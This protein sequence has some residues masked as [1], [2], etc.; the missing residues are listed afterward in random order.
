[1]DQCSIS[2]TDNGILYKKNTQADI[3]GI[4]REID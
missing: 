1:M 4:T 2:K 3:A